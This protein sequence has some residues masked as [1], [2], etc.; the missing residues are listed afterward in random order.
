MTAAS[1]L[2]EGSLDLQSIDYDPILFGD[3]RR[4]AKAASV[5]HRLEGSGF[6]L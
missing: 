1:Q 5:Q 6:L 3:L 4:S 2:V